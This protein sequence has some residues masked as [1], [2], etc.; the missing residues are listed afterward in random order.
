MLASSLPI[1]SIF[2]MSRSSDV[3]VDICIA[4]QG[5]RASE[6]DFEGVLAYH[7]GREARRVV[8]DYEPNKPIPFW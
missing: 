5:I 4:F 2:V 8:Y 1:R 7:D 3:P 6:H